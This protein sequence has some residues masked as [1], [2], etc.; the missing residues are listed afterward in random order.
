MQAV[1]LRFGRE[2]VTNLTTVSRAV[3]G[4]A[5][6]PLG[7]CFRK[8]FVEEGRAVEEDA[9]P[10]FLWFGQVASCRYLR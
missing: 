6:V 9:V 4:F 2:V 10:H 8:R 1:W 3:R 7:R 5:G